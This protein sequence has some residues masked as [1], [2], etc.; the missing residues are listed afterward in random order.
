MTGSGDGKM[1]FKSR[2]LLVTSKTKMAVKM[3]NDMT[4]HDRQTYTLVSR[5]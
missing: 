2:E 3:K 4:R 1:G 5:V